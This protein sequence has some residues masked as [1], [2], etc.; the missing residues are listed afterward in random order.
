MSAL[1]LTLISPCA[2]DITTD[3]NKG[4]LF[5]SLVGVIFFCAAPG[6]YEFDTLNLTMILNNTVNVTVADHWD[7]S[8]R[9]QRSM[10]PVIAQP[11]P[12]VPIVIVSPYL[13][14]FYIIG[15]EL[16]R[17]LRI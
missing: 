6:C 5:I 7:I 13:Y 2:L 4:K 12:L 16:S 3:Y 11:S 8:V 1:Y 9:L 14:N 17:Y 15:T 10:R